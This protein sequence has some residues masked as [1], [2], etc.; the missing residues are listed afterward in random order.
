MSSEFRGKLPLSA[1]FMTCHSVRYGL[2]CWMT[3]FTAMEARV[4]FHEIICLLGMNLE[5]T[6]PFNH[7]I[8]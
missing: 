7:V 1:S 4:T 2:G 6:Y 8:G 3:A 5:L